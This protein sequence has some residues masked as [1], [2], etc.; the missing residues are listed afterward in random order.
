[1]CCSP[2]LC[3]HER[4]DRWCHLWRINREMM[5]RRWRTRR[6]SA[7]F[8]GWAQ[9]QREEKGCGSHQQSER[10]GWMWVEACVFLCVLS[11]KCRN[12]V[13]SRCFLW[14]MLAG[15][16]LNSHWA[17]NRTVG[18]WFL[19]RIKLLKLSRRSPNLRSGR[20]RLLPE[21]KRTNRNLRSG[22]TWRYECWAVC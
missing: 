20:R 1:M 13:R 18:C 2:E 22:P 6:V 15:S 19:M 8:T 7:S 21:P 12:P 17:P 4:A 10:V 11:S 9:S 3:R 5:M 16:S 14:Q